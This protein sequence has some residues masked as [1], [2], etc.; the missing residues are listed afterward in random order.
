MR[1]G[2]LVRA[3]PTARLVLVDGLVAV[4]RS[5]TVLAEADR[6]RLVVLLHMP[7]GERDVEARFPEGL[8]L[9]PRAPW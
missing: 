4:G 2:R 7:F 6:L 3:C 9:W 8:V 5:Q 1:A